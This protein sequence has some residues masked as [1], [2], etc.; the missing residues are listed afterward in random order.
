M[1]NIL[2]GLL[3]RRALGAH[4]VCDDDGGGAGDAGHAVHEHGAARLDRPINEGKCSRK[5]PSNV[6]PTRVVDLQKTWWMYISYDKRKKRQ[7]SDDITCENEQSQGNPCDLLFHARMNLHFLDET[8]TYVLSPNERLQ[9]T[10]NTPLPR[11]LSSP[12]AASVL[13]GM[14]M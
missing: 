3:E 11:P 8:H 7:K 4:E 9:T 1:A 5:L 14:R 6:F 10:N 2:I 12:R 13:T